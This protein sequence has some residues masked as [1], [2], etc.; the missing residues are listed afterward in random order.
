MKNCPYCD[1]L[2]QD[3]AVKCMYCEATFDE[4]IQQKPLAKPNR[5]M[6]IVEC[7]VYG[8][9]NTFNKNDRTTRREHFIYTI[10]MVLIIFGSFFGIIWLVST[11]YVA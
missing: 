5:N 10:F 4:K 6:S 7:I 8:L 2:I 3:N 1:E 11:L 9:K